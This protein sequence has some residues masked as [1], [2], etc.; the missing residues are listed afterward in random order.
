MIQ[1]SAS[2]L[3]LSDFLLVS[4]ASAIAVTLLMAVVFAVAR[5]TGRIV[6]VDTAWG[7]GFILVALVS[8][9]LGGLLPR[10]HIFFVGVTRPGGAFAAID[11]YLHQES[12]APGASSCSWRSGAA[13]WPGTSS[14][15][16][17]AA[18][19]TRATRS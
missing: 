3:D 15:A 2:R 5:R 1:S 12:S 16:P 7:L 11:H 9:V 14:V 13:A 10:G 19:R 8:A 17:G 4:G 18:A 6:V